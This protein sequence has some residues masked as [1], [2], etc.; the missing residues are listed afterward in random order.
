MS[1][2]SMQLFTDRYV[3][4]VYQW[5]DTQKESRPNALAAITILYILYIANNLFKF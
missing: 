4:T 1:A 3:I 5:K 2:K